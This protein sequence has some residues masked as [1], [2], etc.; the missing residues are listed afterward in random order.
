[1]KRLRSTLA[2][3]VGLVL[4]LAGSRMHAA[5]DPAHNELRALR[6]QVIEAI[7]KGDNEAVMRHVHPQV[8]VTWQN[9]EVCRGVQG[10]RDF[11]NRMAKETFRGYKVPP[12]PD[13]L[14]TLYGGDTGVVSGYVVAEYNLLG[15]KLEFK[16]RWT[17]TVVK[18]GGR[19]LLAS[20][21]ISLNALDNPILD[22]AKRSL[23]WVGIGAGVAGLLIGV[24][25]A[26]RFMG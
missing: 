22:T 7:T 18:E 26:R 21:H 20:Y 16:S 23:L 17:A 6:T 25:I 5:E 1:M 12:T 8:V 14:T 9:A 15:K 3:A 19:W 2:L 13:D 11:F 4:G 10:L 24:L